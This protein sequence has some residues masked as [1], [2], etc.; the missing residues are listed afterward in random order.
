M[1][2]RPFRRADLDTLFAIDQACFAAGIAYSKAELRY[3]LQ[4]AN[5]CSLVAENEPEGIA[6]FLVAQ[7]YM[8]QGRRLGHIIT[9]D[10]LPAARRQG[11]GRALMEAVESRFREESVECMRLEVAVDNEPAQEF[12]RSLG[13]KTFGRIPDYYLGRLDALVMQKQLRDAA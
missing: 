9:I 3:F 8:Q 7:R 13:F 1:H 12:Y 4:R 6:G 10:V 11:I 2:L 5:S